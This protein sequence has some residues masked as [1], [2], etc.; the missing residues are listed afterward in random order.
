MNMAVNN[1][2]CRPL[3]PAVA[4]LPHGADGSRFNTKAA[5]KHKDHEMI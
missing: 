2:A 3:I 1:K 4:I 5:K